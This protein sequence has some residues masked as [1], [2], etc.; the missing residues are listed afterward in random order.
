MTTN[1]YLYFFSGPFSNWH[2]SNFVID[3]ISYNCVEQY[4]MYN[5]ALL[6]ANTDIAKQ[7]LT[8][9]NPKEQKKLGRAVKNFDMFYWNEHCIQI[10]FRGCHAKFSQNKRLYDMLMNT[11][12]SMLV[13]ASQ[14]DQIWGIGLNEED[15]KKTDPDK[16]PGK[17][18]LGKTLVELREFFLEE[19]RIEREYKNGRA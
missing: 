11:T 5:K 14:F 19:E 4:V 15:A 17:N 18:W 7:I 8:T 12:P 10:M 2:K 9:N 3:G 1:Q 6:F 13:E 16:W